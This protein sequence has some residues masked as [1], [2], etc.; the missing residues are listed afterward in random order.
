MYKVS[1]TTQKKEDKATAAICQSYIE[2]NNGRYSKR[3]QSIEK[4]QRTV[5]MVSLTSVLINIK[6]DHL[7]WIYY[8]SNINYN[9]SYMLDE[10]SKYLYV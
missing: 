1:T 9:S 2:R 4:R 6:M 8:I 7:I 10:S 3:L 5:C